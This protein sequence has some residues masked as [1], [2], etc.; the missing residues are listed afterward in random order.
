MNSFGHSLETNLPV[1][2]WIGEKD[3]K[4]EYE[5]IQMII[6]QTFKILIQYP[7]LHMSIDK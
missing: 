3:E 1:S 2:S 7:S 6:Q 4:I 5:E